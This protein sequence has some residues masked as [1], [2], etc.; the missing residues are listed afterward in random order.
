MEDL[1]SVQS[2]RSQLRQIR[3]RGSHD[4][5]TI[6]SILD[7]GFLASVGFAIDG[8][9]F[10]IPML[11]ARQDRSLLLHGS[12]A[13]RLM[14]SLSES[15]PVCG[16]VT[17]VD[18][19]VL[20]RSAFNHSMNY[21]S[22]VAFGTARP[23]VD[24]PA[25]VEALRRISDHIVAG[26][27]ADVRRPNRSEL[28]QTTVLEMAIEDA[29]AKVREGPPID[30]LADHNHEAWAGVVP[31][32]LTAATPVPDPQLRA[33]VLPPS[34]LANLKLSRQPFAVEKTG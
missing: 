25:K 10:V 1:A 9:P 32:E 31:L 5:T 13:G 15:I 27:W 2:E 18:G 7:A 24:A 12:A 11:Y 29:S 20:A 34:Y 28:T 17:L 8:H 4:W 30:D 14:T 21:R 19:I 23:I 6:A 16:S 33:G 22:I 3:E 26:R